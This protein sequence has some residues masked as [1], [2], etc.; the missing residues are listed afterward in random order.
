MADSAGLRLLQFADSHKLRAQRDRSVRYLGGSVK[1]RPNKY[2]KRVEVQLAE[3][4]AGERTGFSLAVAP[5]G[6]S[7]QLSVWKQLL[8]R[9][10]GE[11]LFYEDLARALGRPGAAR[12][13][14]SAVGANPVLIVIP[15][16]R[17]VPKAGGLGGYAAASWRKKRLLSLERPAEGRRKRPL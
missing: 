16:H 9:P 4:F 10:F 5:I 14:G 6:T 17:V 13:V 3:Y 11:T 7:W 15:C 8:D 12:A 1:A 2:L